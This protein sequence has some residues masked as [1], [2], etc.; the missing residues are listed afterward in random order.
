MVTLH[1]YIF[2]E[3]LKTLVLAELALTTLLTMGGGL[4]NAIKYEGVSGGDVLRFLPLLIPIVVTLTLPMA[5]LFAVTMVY[6]RLAADNELTACRAAGI[7][8]HRLFLPAIGLSL[9]LGAFTLLVGNFVI[10]GL[11]QRLADFA[12]ESVRDIVAQHL[13]RDGYVQYQE[14]KKKEKG[15]RYTLTARRVQNVA[16]EALRAKQFETGPGLHYL[17]VH[18]PTLLHLDE[19]GRL[20]RFIAARQGLCFFD[21]R[22]N[23]AQITVYVH[24]GRDFDV[25]KHAVSVGQQQI[26][27]IVLPWLSAPVSLTT[28]DLGQLL[29]WKSNP[30]AGPKLAEQI[31]DFL[32]LVARAR[33]HAWC[34][35]HLEQGGTLVLGDARGREYRLTCAAVRTDAKGLVLTD[36]R[37]A[38]HTPGETLPLRYEAAQI[39]L[40][41]R[42]LPSGDL[43][44]EL[45]LVRTTRQDVLEYE[46]YAGGYAAPRRK[47]TLSLDGVQAPADATAS[48]AQCTAAQVLDPT[49]ALAL[50][51]EL[52][53]KRV[54]LQDAGRELQ[55]RILATMHMRLGYTSCVFVIL[56]MGGALGVIF[57]GARALAA[58]A[59]S[60]IPFFSVMILMVLGQKLAADAKTTNIGPLVTWGGLVAVLLADLVVLRV[61]V[62]R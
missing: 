49:V 36:G 52:A 33:F 12:R 51:P 42:P 32:A 26:G 16:E 59:L 15:D 61:G 4:Y 3:L 39:E 7:N 56:L 5:A 31:R 20:V 58:F 19:Q 41:G 28:A 43:L 11:S 25:G 2:V 38:L 8:V 10:P 27:P 24:E 47:P 62:R 6:G 23:S 34:T 30:W 46:P 21:T 57:R 22:A 54:G 29:Y 45:N 37:V 60:T 48:V 40:R 9:V 50:P 53:D 35:A 18:D 1:R 44:I 55:R 14:R 17:L 13:Q